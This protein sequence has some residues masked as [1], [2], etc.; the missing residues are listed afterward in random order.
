MQHLMQH[1]NEYI[2]QAQYKHEA[3]ITRV[4]DYACE[5]FR[6]S[7]G[8]ARFVCLTKLPIT[9]RAGAG[10]AHPFAVCQRK[11]QTRGTSLQPAATRHFG[12]ETPRRRF[13]VL[14]LRVERRFLTTPML[15]RF[16]FLRQVKYC[17]EE[18][19]FIQDD[20]LVLVYRGPEVGLSPLD[21][22]AYPSHSGS[23]YV[24]WLP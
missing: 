8:F 9:S 20:D 16:F 5:M 22:K 14:G 21:T 17:G 12:M 13:K 18:H 3:D 24:A 11:S 23:S 6:K 15:N 19:M 1:L 4:L 10:N 7:A 2:A